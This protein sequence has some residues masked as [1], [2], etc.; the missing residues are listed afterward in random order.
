MQLCWFVNMAEVG[1]EFWIG[2]GE[3][4]KYMDNE[5]E[6]ADGIMGVALELFVCWWHVTLACFICVFGRSRNGVRTVE[7]LG[8]WF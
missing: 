5:M 6:A 7:K 2:D 8:C 3:L 4:E 1:S